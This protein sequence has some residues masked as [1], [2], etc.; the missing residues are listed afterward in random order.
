MRKPFPFR[1]SLSSLLLAALSAGVAC[2]AQDDTP[3][4]GGPGGTNPG[5]STT[6]G[7]NTSAG[8]P[9]AAGVNGSTGG[10]GPSAAGASGSSSGASNTGGAGNPGGGSGGTAPGGGSSAG[11]GPAVSSQEDTGLSCDVT[12]ATGPNGASASTL[13]DP[14][15]KWDGAQVKNM[16]DWRCRRRELVMEVE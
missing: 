16:T 13:P 15:T 5:G 2:G 12:A 9:A 8:M 11:G 3:D 4:G 6:G 10:A 14:F 1:F 7:A